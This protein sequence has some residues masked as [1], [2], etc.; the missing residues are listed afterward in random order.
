MS[1]PYILAAGATTAVA[2]FEYLERKRKRDDDDRMDAEQTLLDAIQWGTTQAAGS[3]GRAEAA[4]DEAAEAAAA[5]EGRGYPWVKY[6]RS[7]VHF[8]ADEVGGPTAVRDRAE[9]ACGA[10]AAVRAEER[11]QKLEEH[12]KLEA[13]QLAAHHEAMRPEQEA[14]AQLKQ[15]KRTL[16]L[17]RI[18][19]RKEREGAEDAA[20]AGRTTAGFQSAAGL[21]GCWWPHLSTRTE[22]AGTE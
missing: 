12:M 6:R 13:G 4:A 8:A 22:S 1:L 14:S 21:Q 11:Q 19:E 2:A 20:G 9:A 10:A 7:K 15:A 16:Q 3:G 5:A 18:A 17:K